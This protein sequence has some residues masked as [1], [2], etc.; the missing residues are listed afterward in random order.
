MRVLNNLPQAD[1]RTV[2]AA[3]KELKAA[4]YDGVMTA[5][6]KHDPFLVHAITAVCTERLH[7]GTSAAVAFPRSPMVVANA[8]WDIQNA[9]KGR[10]VLGPVVN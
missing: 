8:S 10:F 9:S 7:L 5:E 4:V 3:A 2:A 1:L 6:N